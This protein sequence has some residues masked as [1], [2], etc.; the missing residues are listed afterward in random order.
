MN[1]KDFIDVAGSLVANPRSGYPEARYRSA[2]SRAYYGSYHFALEVL[3]RFGV[4]V[5]KGPNGHQTVKNHFLFSKNDTALEAARRIG[6]LGHERNTADY[7]LENK[8]Y[9]EERNAKYQVERAS[10]VVSLLEQ[11]L[12]EPNF[13]EIKAYFDSAQSA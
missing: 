8:K 7:K 1:S 12:Q 13:T 10:E 2:V 11:C 5:P 4:T 3:L 9:T 6:D